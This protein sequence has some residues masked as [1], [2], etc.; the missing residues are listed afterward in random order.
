MHIN[1]RP[2]TT[3]YDDDLARTVVFTLW[4]HESPELIEIVSEMLPAWAELFARKNAEYQDG[5]GSAFALGER[6]QF[7][8]IY[9]KMMKL[10]LAM[11]EGKED[12]LT[13]E[14]VDEILMDLIGHCFLTLVMRQR[15]LQRD[16]LFPFPGSA[17][18]TA[19]GGD[20]L[21]KQ[22][23]EFVL[24]DGPILVLDGQ[25][26]DGQA[27]FI[28]PAAKSV[29]DSIAEYS[30]PDGPQEITPDSVFSLRPIEELIRLNIPMIRYEQVIF[31]VGDPVRWIQHMGRGH[32]AVIESFDLS[33]ANGLVVNVRSKDGVIA[34]SH[35]GWLTLDADN[36]RP[37]VAEPG[38][39]LSFDT[40][41]PG[42]RGR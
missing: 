30:F 20:S 8:D 39:V 16:R 21:G 26:T 34:P 3:Q 15:R 23:G 22:A 41:D 35:P 4:G 9:R 17:G 37:Q 12:E 19:R 5:I 38:T 32:A 14:G 31:A 11:W 2:A 29:R 40:P 7:S 25:V 6:G 24:S 27:L 42:P 28:D 1:V 33:A 18:D 36:L 13:S 10:K